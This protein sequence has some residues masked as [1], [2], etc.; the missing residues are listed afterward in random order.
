MERMETG[1]L[2]AGVDRAGALEFVGSIEAAWGNVPESLGELAF[3]PAHA[4]AMLVRGSHFD[5]TLLRPYIRDL[6]EGSYVETYAISLGAGLMKDLVRLRSPFPLPANQD[7][8]SYRVLLE[9]AARNQLLM[10]LDDP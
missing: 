2:L 7:T 6:I 9:R 4:E 5:A 8:V 1:S 3:V 10:T